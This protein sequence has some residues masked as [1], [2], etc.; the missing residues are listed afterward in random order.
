MLQL[1]EYR[2]DG[3]VTRTSGIRVERGGIACVDLRERRRDVSCVLVWP[4]GT[5]R[6]WLMAARLVG[7]GEHA[8][9]V[10]SVATLC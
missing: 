6:S 2:V 9:F 4:G 10:H 7:R 3:Q 1:L 8:G 5:C